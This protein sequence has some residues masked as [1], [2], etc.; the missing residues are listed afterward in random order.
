VCNVKK[1][2]YTGRLRFRDGS[3][4]EAQWNAGHIVEG[5]SKYFFAE[6]SEWLEPAF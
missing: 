3:S 2:V 1:F 6:D 5:S 4:L